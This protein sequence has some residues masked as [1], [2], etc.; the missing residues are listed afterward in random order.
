MDARA[1]VGGVHWDPRAYDRSFGFVSEHGLALVDLL[2]P[3]QGE[4]VLDLGCGTGALAAQI[5]A[6][7]ATVEGLDADPRMVERA[8]AE[9]PGLHFRLGDA[10][11]FTVD[12]PVDAVFSNA[13]LHWVAETD[14]RSVL[15][16]VRRALRPGGRFV[17][18]MGGAGNVTTLVQAAAGA[19]ASLQLPPVDPP[20]CFPSPAQQAGRLEDAGFGVR[21]IEHFARPTELTGTDTAAD[22]TAM[23]GQYA[24]A[25]VPADLQP[26]LLAELDRLASSALRDARGRW[27]ADCVRLRWWAVAGPV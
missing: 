21:L 4:Q 3:R 6:R 20:W 16:A 19:R 1:T 7:G 8:L 15:A 12:Q 5:A 25:D 11:T 9:H 18:E 23:F 2:D 26:V 13:V 27:T 17:A 24:L 14:Q 10:T 22:W